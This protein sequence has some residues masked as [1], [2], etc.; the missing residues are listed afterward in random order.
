M[1][2]QSGPTDTARTKVAD[3][4]SVQAAPVR[5]VVDRHVQRSETAPCLEVMDASCGVL[6]NEARVGHP[7]VGFFAAGEGRFAQVIPE[8]VD[9]VPLPIGEA[10]PGGVLGRTS[11]EGG[12]RQHL[13][14]FG[15]VGHDLFRCKAAT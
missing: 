11:G 3:I 5:W 7:A 8:L 1:S 12:P 9:R 4:G 15:H 13:D 14:L 2:L 10:L 6:L